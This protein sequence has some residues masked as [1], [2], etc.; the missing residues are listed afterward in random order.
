MMNYAAAF[1]VVVIVIAL[2]FVEGDVSREV[3]E[4][5]LV[6]VAALDDAEGALA[7]EVHLHVGEFEHD[8]A[9]TV[10]V[11]VV[12]LV[13]AAEDHLVQQLAH[14]LVALLKPV[15]P[16]LRTG[17]SDPLLA[18]AAQCLITLQAVMRIRDQV[19]AHRA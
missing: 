11:A 14:K 5:A 15:V 18:L 19:E 9:D 16:A 6:G 3:G 2:G 1:V 10:R 17:I 12:L 13:R 4:L 8:F 7:L